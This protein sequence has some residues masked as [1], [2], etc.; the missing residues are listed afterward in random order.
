MNRLE[1]YLTVITTVL[2]L[3]QVIRLVQNMTQL[4]HIQK[5]HKYDD[6]ILSVYEKLEKAINK[7]MTDKKLE[8]Q[9]CSDCKYTYYKETD[10]P[11]N[12]CKNNHLMYFKLK[13]TKND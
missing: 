4:K 8:E 1:I 7:Y 11:C 13:E 6:Y 2:V 9:N 10:Q 5:M 12:D 3:T